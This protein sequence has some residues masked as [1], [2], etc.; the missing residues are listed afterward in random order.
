MNGEILPHWVWL[1]Y[2]GFLLLILIVSIRNMRK[3][4]MQLLSIGALFFVIA[5][6]VVSIVNSLFLIGT[7]ELLHFI[8]EFEAGAKWSYFALAGYLY[9]V[10]YIV[11][12]GLRDLLGKISI[13]K[14]ASYHK[15]K[16]NQIKR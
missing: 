1:L 15:V 4:K 2:Y 13:N 9:M 6:P 5:V 7:N 3:S 14:K 10:L 8:A 11:V 16:W 12:A